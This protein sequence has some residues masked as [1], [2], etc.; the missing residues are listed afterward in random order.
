MCCVRGMNNLVS[1]EILVCPESPDRVDAVSF[2]FFIRY[3]GPPEKAYLTGNYEKNEMPGDL[4][5]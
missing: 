3:A 2:Y 5:I 4:T 1:K